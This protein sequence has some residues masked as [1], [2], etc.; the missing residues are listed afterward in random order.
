M[1]IDGRNVASDQIRFKVALRSTKYKAM[2][3]RKTKSAEYQNSERLALPLKF[4]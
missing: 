1:A 4:T 3:T 2:A